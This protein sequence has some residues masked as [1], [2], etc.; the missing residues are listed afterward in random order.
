MMAPKSARDGSGP[1]ATFSSSSKLPHDNIALYWCTLTLTGAWDTTIVRT[2]VLC[3]VI[4]VPR[5]LGSSL[6]ENHPSFT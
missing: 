6:N 1:W 4:W 3:S 5:A 2:Y